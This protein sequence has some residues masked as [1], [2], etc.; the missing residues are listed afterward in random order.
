MT[1]YAPMSLFSYV[2]QI[3]PRQWEAVGVHERALQAHRTFTVGTRRFE[4]AVYGVGLKLERV[5]LR[6]KHEEVLLQSFHGIRGLSK[7]RH[8]VA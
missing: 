8:F 5:P 3:K 7:G 2:E 4:L 1:L 6:L